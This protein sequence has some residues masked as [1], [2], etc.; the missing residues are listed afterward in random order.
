MILCDACSDRPAHPGTWLCD[1]CTDQLHGDLPSAVEWWDELDVERC[2]LSRKGGGGVRGTETALPFAPEATAAQ[3]AIR[4]ALHGLGWLIGAPHTIDLPALAGMLID[5][6]AKLPARDGIGIAAYR[7]REALREAARLCG[8]PPEKR[9]YLG[10][11]ATCGQPMRTARTR[12]WH[13]CCDQ[14]YDVEQAHAETL[15]RLHDPDTNYTLSEAALLTGVAHA[16][17]RQRVKRQNIRPVVGEG[18]GAWYRLGDL[19]G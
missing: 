8:R 17:L 16:T 19:T 12:G 4:D 13:R 1:D 2:R 3:Q 18:K 15:A 9:V 5:Q 6:E 7:L 10:L 14:V 11:C